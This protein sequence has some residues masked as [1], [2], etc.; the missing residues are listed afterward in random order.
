MGLYI[1]NRNAAAR[2][3]RQRKLTGRRLKPKPLYVAEAEFPD[4]LDS[5]ILTDSGG[6]GVLVA[7]H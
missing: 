3:C 5:K 7:M 1:H 2:D 4:R 6:V